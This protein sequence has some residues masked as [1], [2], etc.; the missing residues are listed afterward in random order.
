MVVSTTLNHRI[1]ENVVT[2]RSRSHIEKK[3]LIGYNPIIQ[4]IKLAGTEVFVLRLDLIHPLISGN[5][6][7]KL[8]YNVEEARKQGCDTI[9]TFGGAFSNHILATAVACKEFGF[10]SVGVIRGE[11]ASETNSTLSEAK[12]HGM[13]L[14]FVSREDYDLK[15]NENYIEGFRNW[16]GNFYVVPEGGNNELGI[17]GCGEVLPKENDFDIIFCASGTGTTFKGI[18]RSLKKDQK[19]F[20]ISVVKGVGELNSLPN[21]IS[22]YHFSGYAKHTKV[23]LEFKN[24]FEKEHNIP[25]D[26]VYTAK[27]F[28][29]V[30]DLISKNKI[31]DG[32]KV[33]VIHSGGLQGNKGYE[34]RYLLIP[35]RNVNDAQGNDCL[36]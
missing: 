23:L 10:K 26:Y 31:P 8:K 16:F 28:F 5:K 20:G 12:K 1:F 24:E 32:K 11:K 15:E 27:L 22:D 17:K 25:L 29:A 33:L 18:E 3:K 2:E 7:F 4:K 36:G 30:D 13:Q 6:W 19:L 9:L 34:E 35:N 21:M 14:A